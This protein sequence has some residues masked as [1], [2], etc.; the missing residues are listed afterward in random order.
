MIPGVK[1][2]RLG[3]KMDCPVEIALFE[4]LD[5]LIVEF[6]RLFTGNGGKGRREE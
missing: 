4:G 2:N 1:L 5:P 3:E 6:H